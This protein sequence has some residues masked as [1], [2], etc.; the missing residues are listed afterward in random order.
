MCPW[1]GEIATTPL[2]VVAVAVSVPVLAA[3]PDPVLETP[4]A[5][6]DPAVLVDIEPP[7]LDVVAPDDEL[8]SPPQPVESVKGPSTSAYKKR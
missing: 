7:P 6:P 1:Q 8:P 3:P 5:P 2:P 4:P